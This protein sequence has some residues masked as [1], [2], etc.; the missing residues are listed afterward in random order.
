MLHCLSLSFSN[1]P[2]FVFE[3]HF[4]KSLTEKHVYHL[5][6][7]KTSSNLI[8]THLSQGIIFQECQKEITVTR[9]LLRYLQ[10]YHHTRNDP[11]PG[12]TRA[13]KT[14]W[15]RLSVYALCMHRHAMLHVLGTCSECGNITLS[16]MAYSAFRT[17]FGTSYPMQC[18]WI[19]ARKHVL[20]MFRL[21]RSNC[22]S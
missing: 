17:D 14:T 7:H 4:P 16:Y 3:I 9:C 15:I 8:H 10:S 2:I 6:D 13:H 1:C 20:G 12:L 5:N 19:H 11:I 18:E 22:D 21:H